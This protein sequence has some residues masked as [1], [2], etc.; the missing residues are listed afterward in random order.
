MLTHAPVSKAKDNLDDPVNATIA[1]KSGVATTLAMA[2]PA[3]ATLKHV[4][5]ISTFGLFPWGADLPP[6][7]VQGPDYYESEPVWEQHGTL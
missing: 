7:T 1:I 3:V 5:S 2:C 6:T 4:D